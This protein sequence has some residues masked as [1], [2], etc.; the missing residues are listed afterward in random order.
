MGLL[1]LTFGVIVF[2]AHRYGPQRRATQCRVQ[3]QERRECVGTW[4]AWFF[5]DFESAKKLVSDF[6]VILHNA[7]ERTFYTREISG[8]LRL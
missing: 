6:L 5:W 3:K 8:I 7:F 1:I 2:E 4:L